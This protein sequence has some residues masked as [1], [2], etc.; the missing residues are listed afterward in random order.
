MTL[1][2]EIDM[3]DPWEIYQNAGRDNDVGSYKSIE[4][5]KSAHYFY[6][7]CFREYSLFLDMYIYCKI[8]ISLI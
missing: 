8:R 5:T 3:N 1:T 2:N 7:M 6:L 4:N